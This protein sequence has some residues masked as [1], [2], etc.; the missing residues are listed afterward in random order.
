MTYDELDQRA[1]DLAEKAEQIGLRTG[2]NVDLWSAAAA[3]S[4]AEELDLDAIQIGYIASHARHLI[5]AAERAA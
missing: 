3:L 4:V 2:R 1:E 5:D